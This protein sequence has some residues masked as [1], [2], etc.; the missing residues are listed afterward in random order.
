MTPPSHRNEVMSRMSEL[1]RRASGRGITLFLENEKGIYGDTAAR[2]ADM[3]ETVGSPVFISRVRPGQLRRS[4]AADRPSLVVSFS[5]GQALP[6]Q[7][8]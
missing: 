2:V 8:F 4:R 3:I 6:R 1:A 5:L 7:G